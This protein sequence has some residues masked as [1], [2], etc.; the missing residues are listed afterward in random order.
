[1]EGLGE[2]IVGPALHGL[3][4]GFHAPVS[5]QHQGFKLRLSFLELVQQLDA[6]QVGQVKIEEGHVE[7]FLLGPVQGVGGSGG[8]SHLHALTP[9]ASFQGLPQLIVVIHNQQ[10]HRRGRGL[11]SLGRAGRVFGFCFHNGIFSPSRSFG[12]RRSGIVVAGNHGP[13]L[14]ALARPVASIPGKRVSRCSRTY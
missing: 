10:P 4:G 7:A 5:R 12:N 11:N 3:D 6:G 2:V 1:M 8:G 14:S 13:L 9:K